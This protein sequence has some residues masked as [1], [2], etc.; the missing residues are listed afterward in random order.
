MAKTHGSAERYSGWSAF[1]NYVNWLASDKDDDELVYTLDSGPNGSTLANARYGL[2][3]GMR[4]RAY[5]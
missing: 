3:E 4:R 1:F 2:L 5:G